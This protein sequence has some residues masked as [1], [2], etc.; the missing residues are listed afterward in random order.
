[1]YSK[2]SKNLKIVLIW[3]NDN[4]KITQYQYEGLFLMKPQTVYL[5]HQKIDEEEILEI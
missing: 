3:N 5:F 4:K 1:M 2:N